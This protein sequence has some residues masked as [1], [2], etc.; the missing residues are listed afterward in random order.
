[1]IDTLRACGVVMAYA[2]V[3]IV[4][5]L[6]VAVLAVPMLVVGVCD[7]ACR[8]VHAAKRGWNEAA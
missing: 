6:V 3:V 7:V 4:I 2:C 1:M 8:A 5:A